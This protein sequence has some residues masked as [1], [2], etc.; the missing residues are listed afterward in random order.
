[1]AHSKNCKWVN[2]HDI[3]LHFKNSTESQYL[4]ISKLLIRISG[5]LASF[6]KLDDMSNWVL[7]FL[8]G[9]RW[10][11]PLSD[12][13]M[14]H[15]TSSLLPFLS[16]PSHFVHLPARPSPCR[17][18]S[19]TTSILHDGDWWRVWQKKAKPLGLHFQKVN[20][21]AKG[22]K[23]AK[24]FNNI[25]KGLLYEKLQ[26]CYH[27]WSAHYNGA[28]NSYHKILI[29]HDLKTTELSIYK[30]NTRSD[31]GLEKGSGLG[32]QRKG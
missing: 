32:M 14:C 15:S 25:S 24:E 31:E 26:W 22:E 2:S 17:D 8:C 7:H 16:H 12:G 10:E 11:V 6:N 28:T 1:M 23:G 9:S 18:L 3:D 13:T 5:Y 21:T 4:K 30:I 19:F 20:Q 29:R 27:P